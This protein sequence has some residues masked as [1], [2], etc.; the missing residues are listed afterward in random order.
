MET[1]C[2]LGGG[3][4][5]LR[6]YSSAIAAT[7][8]NVGLLFSPLKA[9]R[10]RGSL[11]GFTR[12]LTFLCKAWL[13]GPFIESP[14]VGRLWVVSR[15]RGGVAKC[16]TCFKDA[17]RADFVSIGI[18]WYW[19]EP[20][21]TSYRLPFLLPEHKLSFFPNRLFWVPVLLGPVCLN[22]SVCLFVCVCVRK[23][24]FVWPT[25]SFCCFCLTGIKDVIYLSDKYH[26][27]PEMTASRRLLNLAGITYKWVSRVWP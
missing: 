18:G 15:M 25:L 27:T 5:S 22:F 12:F 4:V 16:T 19:L 2:I 3:C 17:N 13:M 8:G 23:C 24:A 7:V 11:S 14:H 21:A 6:E 10:A 1:L 20:A 9:L 26:D